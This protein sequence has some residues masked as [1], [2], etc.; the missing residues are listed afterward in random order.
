M[1]VAGDLADE[2]TTKLEE[3][4]K[5]LAEQGPKICSIVCSSFYFYSNIVIVLASLYI[6]VLAL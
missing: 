5:R 3:A 6:I 4:R 2:Y 1:E